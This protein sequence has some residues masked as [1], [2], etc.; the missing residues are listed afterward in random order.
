MTAALDLAYLHDDTS[1][2]HELYDASDGLEHL[3]RLQER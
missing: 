1:E 3:A 2:L